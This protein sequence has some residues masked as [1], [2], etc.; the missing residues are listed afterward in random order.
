MAPDPLY[1]YVPVRGFP[2]DLSLACASDLGLTLLHDAM[3]EPAKSNA[4]RIAKRRE[5]CVAHHARVEENWAKK[6]AACK[7]ASPIAPASPQPL[8]PR[9]LCVQGW[10]SSF[11]DRGSGKSSARGTE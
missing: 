3:V 7:D 1:T 5:E 10:L 4:V 6:L 2:A 9:G 11:S 8:A